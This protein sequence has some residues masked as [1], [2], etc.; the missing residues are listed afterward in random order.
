MKLKRD[1]VRLPW[2][3][4]E[5]DAETSTGQQITLK[6]KTDIHATGGVRTCN[7]NKR[8][9]SQAQTLDRMVNG[10]GLMYG[11]LTPN[12]T[13]THQIIVEIQTKIHI[14]L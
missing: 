3:S 12:F 14:S 10:I 2:T 7:T 8:K 1:W 13:K 5:A 11:Y 4:D 9:E 6:K